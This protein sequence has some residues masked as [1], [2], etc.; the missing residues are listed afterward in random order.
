VSETK[1]DQTTAEPSNQPATASPAPAAATQLSDLMAQG[2]AAA[3]KVDAGKGKAGP[4]LEREALQAAQ[5]AIAEGERALANARAQLAAQA[6]Q[7]PK[8]RNGREL[9]L[10]LLLAANVLAMI[11]VAALPG[12]PGGGTQPTTPASHQP[13]TEPHGTAAPAPRLDD[14]YVA[15]MA[16]AAAND[17]QKAISLLEAYL[18]ESP[19]MAPSSRINV[20]LALAHYSMRV[21]NLTAAQEYERKVAA[22]SSSAS[23]PDD[24]VKM[25][26][27][28]LQGGDQESLRRIWARFLLQQRQVPTSLYKHVAEAYLQLGDSYRNQAN[29]AAERQRLQELEAA[30]AR[31]RAEADRNPGK[32]K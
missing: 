15:A 3:P 27:A 18:A 23:L 16:A 28:A 21:G 4:D 25:A 9:A 20:L 5:Q 8:R 32:V 24:L 29:E 6:Q 2:A 31:L 22:L 1:G 19:R 26:Q 10:R 14:K 17:H 30:A 12:A 7:E 11:V 13:T